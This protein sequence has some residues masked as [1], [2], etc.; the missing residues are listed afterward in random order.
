MDDVGETVG[1]LVC[2][3]SSLVGRMCTKLVKMFLRAY[4]CQCMMM[5]IMPVHDD[6]VCFYYYKK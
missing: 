6:D 3:L 2:V 5:M 4:S 1:G